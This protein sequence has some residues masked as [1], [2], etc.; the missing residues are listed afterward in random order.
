MARYGHVLA[1]NRWAASII[2]AHHW[3][4]GQN[5]EFMRW[6]NLYQSYSS[7][8]MHHL[9]TIVLPQRL[10]NSFDFYVQMFMLSTKIPD[11]WSTRLGILTSSLVQAN[12][13]SSL[14]GSYLK[15]MMNGGWGTS[16]FMASAHQTF[17][18]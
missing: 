10:L 6:G 14:V 2:H 17:F 12:A 1:M 11:A 8:A 4:V 16:I 7:K 5:I 13:G 3:L 15:R 18:L 9:V